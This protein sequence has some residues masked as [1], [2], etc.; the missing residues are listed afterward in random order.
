MFFNLFNS[1]EN[2]NKIG[3][4]DVVYAINNVQKHLLINTLS[5]DLQNCLIKNTL[6]IENET[7]ILNQ[8]IEKTEYKDKIIIIYGANSID[9]NV[10]KKYKQ[11]MDL[12]FT[13]IYIYNGG[14]FE[15]LLLQDIYGQDNFPTTSSILD[16]LKYKP[17]GKLQIPLL[18]L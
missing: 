17:R 15:W 13:N 16:I 4:E 5:N 6:S 10:E 2:N 1:K 11:L 12:G 18:G 8:I 9:N 14:L 3:Y 7:Y